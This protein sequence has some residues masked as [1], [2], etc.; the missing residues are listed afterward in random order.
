MKKVSAL[1]VTYNRLS[2]LKEC[3]AAL[4]NSDYTVTN[5]IIVNNASTDETSSFLKQLVSKNPEL[6]KVVNSKHNLGG[7]GGFNLGFKY[8][9]N[10]TNTDYLWVMDD[11]TIVQKSTLTY[12]M[13]PFDELTNI[14]YTASNVLWTDHSPVLMNVGGPSTDWTRYAELGYISLKSSS[15]VSLVIP[16][17]VIR[18]VGYPISDFFIWGDDVE[19]TLRI[20]R[21]KKL[22]VFVGNSLV[23]H[24]MKSN[25]GIDI[26]AEN[27]DINRIKRYYFEF[28]NNLY[29]RRNNNWKDMVNGVLGKPLLIM[30]VLFKKNQHKGLKIWIIIKGTLAGLCF[31]PK[32][33]KV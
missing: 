12:L 4:V 17:S 24:K 10:H 28:R 2:L 8:F 18:L 15:F 29:N 27:N 33:E 6:Y 23:V 25:T 11:D 20:T 5:I 14:G 13:Q 22:N 26:V 31:N 16:R 3:L 30:K 1:V 21:A 7:A 9:I 32:I 19:Y